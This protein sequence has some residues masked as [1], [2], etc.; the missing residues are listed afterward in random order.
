MDVFKTYVCVKLS[1]K[2]KGLGIAKH[3]TM[4]LISLLCRF[5]VIGFFS[6]SYSTLNKNM[7][8]FTHLQISFSAI[9]ISKFIKQLMNIF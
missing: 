6:K 3:E 4:N 2:R 7:K 9:S 8:E 5:R 1:N